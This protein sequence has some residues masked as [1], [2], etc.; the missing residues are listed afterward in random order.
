MGIVEGAWAIAIK[1]HYMGR[2]ESRTLIL[3]LGAT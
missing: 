3:E 2:G 1:A